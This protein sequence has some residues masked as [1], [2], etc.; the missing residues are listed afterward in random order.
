[1]TLTQILQKIRSAFYTKAETD[2]LLGGK[3]DT[4]HNHNSTY[5][6]IKAKAESAK[7][8]DSATKATKDSDGNQINTTYAKKILMNQCAWNSKANEWGNNFISFADSNNAR[9]AYIQPYFNADGTTD[10]VLG[11]DHGITK[12]G[13][14]NSAGSAPANGGTSTAS[15]YL[16][17]YGT[18]QYGVNRLQYFNSSTTTTSG[19]SNVANPTQDW[20]YHIIQSHANGAGYYFDIA[21]HFHSNSVYYRRIAGGMESGWIKFIDSDNIGSQSVNYANSA[22]SATNATNATQASYSNQLQAFTGDDFT[23][24]NHFVKAIRSTSGWSTRLWMCYNGGAKTSNEISVAY[25]DS[26]GNANSLG[27]LSHS[28]Y[29]TVSNMSTSGVGCIALLAYFPSNV[30]DFSN[31]EGTTRPG[32][33]L[34]TVYWHLGTSGSNAGDSYYGG[35]SIVIRKDLPKN[36]TWKQLNYTTM[37]YSQHAVISFWVRIS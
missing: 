6:G 1:M 5:L 25:A 27:G 3:S 13:Y 28:E 14:A 15:A 29:P 12:C 22:G 7:S 33:S 23:G 37:G 24:G 18:L 8:A 35:E 2:A 36:G 20:Y 19:A 9:V 34:Y 17:D 10:L 32:S 4:S 26:A 16:N 30:S 31:N 11:A 21:S